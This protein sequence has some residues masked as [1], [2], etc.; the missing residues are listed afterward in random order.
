[1]IWLMVVGIVIGYLIL[2]LLYSILGGRYISNYDPNSPHDIYFNP[3]AQE[4][5]KKNEHD[6]RNW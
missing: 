2:G 6:S 3:V 4:L 5:K 1:M